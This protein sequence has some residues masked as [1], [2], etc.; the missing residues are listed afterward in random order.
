[1]FA[2][3]VAMADDVDD[4][5]AAV[6]SYYAAL[7]S[8]NGA[9]LV[10]LRIP[11][12]S[13]FGGSGLIDR[14]SSSA[15]QRDDFQAL[16]DAG[17]K[18]DL[19]LRHVEVRVYGNAAV[20]TGYSTGTNTAPDGTVNQTRQQRTGVWIKQGGQWREAHRHAS[21][22]AI[23]TPRIEDRFVGTW[24]F[25]SSEQRN[26]KGEVVPIENPW[27]KGV[28][29]YTPTGQMAGQLERGG[30]QKYAA[31]QP[32]GEEAQAALATYLAYY[33]PFTVNEAEG[34]VTHHREAHLNPGSVRDAVRSYQF[35]GNRLMLTPPA[36][37]VDGEELTRT[38]TW[39]RI[40]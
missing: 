10:Q 6:Q 20:V 22:L 1:M 38:L 40:E 11:E 4:V 28:I 19:Q 24:R 16:A 34:T 37:V 9:A 5:K 35:S 2:T 17:R 23:S 21:P 29:M 12:Y 31:D 33:G 26:A 7:N 30:R 39:E 3:A 13:F 25:V 18:L 27:T 32:T 8:G 36:R 15:Q 14:S